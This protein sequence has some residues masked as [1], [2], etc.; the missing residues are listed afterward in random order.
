MH[1]DA[2]ETVETH[3]PVSEVAIGEVLYWWRT[4]VRRRERMR[5]ERMEREGRNDNSP[6]IAPRF[7]PLHA[8]PNAVL[9]VIREVFS[10]HAVLLHV[11]AVKP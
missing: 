10:F 9:F 3:L 6:N 5:R 4:E 2:A 11:I 7:V 1:R 8:S